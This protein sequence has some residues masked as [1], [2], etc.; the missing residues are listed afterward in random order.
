[1]SSSR[2]VLAGI[3]AVGR[4]G[5][6]PGERLEPQEFVVDLDLT[7]DVSEDSLDATVDYRVVADAVKDQV[8]NGSF[9]LLETLAEAVARAVYQFSGISRA[10]AVVHKP[11]AARSMGVE[12]VSAEATIA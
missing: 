1:M 4:H 6:N 10:T 5:A 8:Q 2:I 11:S 12:D 7:V 9:E 3:R